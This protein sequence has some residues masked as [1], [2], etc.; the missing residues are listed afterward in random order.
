MNEPAA[1]AAHTA[2]RALALT[3]LRAQRS[4][5]QRAAEIAG[6]FALGML[7]AAGVIPW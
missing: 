1:R 3:E 2:A 5:W 7:A 4:G 6:L